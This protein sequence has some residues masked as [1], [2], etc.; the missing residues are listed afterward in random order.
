MKKKPLKP[1][2]TQVTLPAEVDAW[3]RSQAKKEGLGKSTYIRRIC[4]EEM[5]RQAQ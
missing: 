3:V 2:L 4:I 5:D 1:I